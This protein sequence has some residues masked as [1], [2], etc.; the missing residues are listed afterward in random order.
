MVACGTPAHG[1]VAAGLTAPVNLEEKL[2]ASRRKQPE[3]VLYSKLRANARVRLGQ[4]AGVPP[5]VASPPSALYE[6]T[7]TGKVTTFWGQQS[8][9]CGSA[10]TSWRG[11]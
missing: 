11:H 4:H 3:V 9:K 2:L 10:L 6:K 7:I 5:S 8:R 1:G